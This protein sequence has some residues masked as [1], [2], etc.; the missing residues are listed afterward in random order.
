[1]FNN[2]KSRNSVLYMK[3]L[4]SIIIPVYNVAEFLPACIDSVICQSYKEIEILLIN[5]GSSDGSGGIC[6]EYA[7]RDGRIRVI[8]KENGGLSDAR[9]VGLDNARG[10]Y[11]S[12]IDSDDVINEM[13]I[14]ILLNTL[15]RSEASISMCD[16]A[17]FSTILPQIL[18]TENDAFELYTG[19]YMLNNLYSKQWVPKNVIACN[20]LYKRSI[21]EDLRYKVGV[22]HE[23]EYVIHH[24]YSNVESVAYCPVKLYYYRQREASI[25]K[26][27]SSKRIH[28]LLA[29]FD[30]RAAFFKER[31]YDHLISE[32]AA[33][34]LLNIVLLA[35]SYNNVE[36]QLLIKQNLWEI[37]KQPNISFKLKFSSVIL[38]TF[39][40]IFWTVKN[41]KRAVIK[42]S[43]VSI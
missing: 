34:K 3:P 24:L 5:D 38:A 10:E 14:M 28:D 7:K 1:M 2:T 32:N 19:E 23:D 4:V 33:A 12:F 30:L 35:I 37:L 22:L 39:P 42:N 26:E 40:K 27:I 25:T 15:S 29:I 18:H 8:H 6:E 36:P 41:L 31:G 13:F 20:K 9:N 17:V 21:W 16:Y 11:F 43:V